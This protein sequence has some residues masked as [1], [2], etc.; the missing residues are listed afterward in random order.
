[1]KFSIDE[2]TPAQ[3]YK[4]MAATLVPR[5][6]AW[7]TTID[8]GGGLNCG[9]FS[10][11]NFFHGEPPVVAL[12]ISGRA[13]HG[14]LGQPGKDTLR[15]I[16]S[17]KEFVINLVSFD[18]RNEMN[19]TSIDFPPEE[20]ELAA[21]NLQVLPSDTVS[22]PR[23]AD[24]PVSYECRCFNTNNT[25]GGATLVLGHVQMVHVR[26]D[27]VLDRSA[28]YID[29]AKLDLIGRMQGGGWYVRTS[30]LFRMPGLAMKEWKERESAG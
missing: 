14:A 19:I 12:G 17:S 5:P 21:A 16:L 7:V 20:D 24:S 6:I 2:L 29:T 3:Q 9:P 11:F 28:C 15:N 27:A 10:F 25:G 22:P 18:L 4:L 13:Q 1:V 26:D 23:I 8:P 30:A